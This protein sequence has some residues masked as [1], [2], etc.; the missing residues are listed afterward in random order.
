MNSKQN[1]E[2]KLFGVN[3]K[4]KKVGSTNEKITFMMCYTYEE[5]ISSLLKIKGGWKKI[6]I[7]SIQEYDR[8]TN[9]YRNEPILADDENGI[10]YQMKKSYEESL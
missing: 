9:E 3:L 10:I 8:E 4:W 5:A 7:I 6:D 1:N 2:P